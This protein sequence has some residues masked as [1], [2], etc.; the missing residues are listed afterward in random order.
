MVREKKGDINERN[1]NG[2][3]PIIVAASNGHEKAIQE[4]IKAKANLND[5]SYKRRTAVYE[6]ARMQH[7]HILRVLLRQRAIASIATEDQETALQL[8]V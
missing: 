6:A 1:D 4:L 7:W 2:W 3:T 8:A 5:M